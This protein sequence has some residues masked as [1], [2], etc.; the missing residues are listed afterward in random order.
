MVRVARRGV[1]ECDENTVAMMDNAWV[2]NQGIARGEA[3]MRTRS[4]IV[5]FEKV[6]GAKRANDAHYCSYELS[7]ENEKD[8]GCGSTQRGEGRKLSFVL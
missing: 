1:N 8:P 7:V 6:V 5:K 3:E 4:H 2:R